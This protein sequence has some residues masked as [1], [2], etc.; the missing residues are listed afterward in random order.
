M[1]LLNIVVWASTFF[2]TKSYPFFL[3][4]ILLAYGLGLRHGVDADHIATIDNAIRKLIQDGKRPLAAGLFFSLG[5][6]TIV[7]ILS[8]LAAFSSSLI[9]NNLPQ[10]KQIG[11]I[12]GAGVSSIFLI[13]IGLINLFIFIDLYKIW[14]HIGKRGYFYEAH[15][16]EHLHKRGLIARILSPLLKTVSGSLSLYPIGL[17]FGLG[18]DTASEVALLSL[19]A[20]S[21][22]KDL[23][24]FCLLLIP[25]A[26]TAGMT[27]IDSLDGIFMLGAYGWAYIKP[28]RKLYYNLNITFIS[29]I[30]ALVIGSIEGI[31]VIGKQLGKNSG[32]FS[33]AN[34][35]ELTYLGY[36]IIGAFIISLLSSAVIYRV[37]KYDSKMKNHSH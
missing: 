14:R 32:I 30:V 23:P 13:I 31:Q 10:L 7:I 2:Y 35:I 15:I 5:H 4:L 17:L 29:V 33:V 27:L 24:L 18:F 19:S 9:T 16:D 25:L 1:L 34:K 11:S 12:I 22:S 36:I 26:F 28:V 20:V 6:S 37:K 21:G 8:L 3:G